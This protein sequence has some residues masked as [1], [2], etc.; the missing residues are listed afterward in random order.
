MMPTGSK[1]GGWPKS[2]EIDIMESAGNVGCRNRNPSYFV[3]TL[4]FGSSSSTDMFGRASK[5][6]NGADLSKAFHTYKLEWSA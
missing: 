4:H 1:Y 2:G 3:S 5:S 6:Y